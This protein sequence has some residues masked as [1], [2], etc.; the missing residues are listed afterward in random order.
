M[1][2]VKDKIYFNM[3]FRYFTVLYIIMQK[4][5]TVFWSM[6]WVCGLLTV[7]IEANNNLRT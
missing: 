5:Y 2:H 7:F 4:Q 3:K 6:R 1:S